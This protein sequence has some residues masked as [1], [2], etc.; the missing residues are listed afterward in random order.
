M[1]STWIRDP[2][3]RSKIN[4]RFT[5]PRVGFGAGNCAEKTLLAIHRDV[6]A[7][8]PCVLQN[9]KAWIRDPTAQSKINI[10]FTEPHVGLAA[11][12]CDEKTLLIVFKEVNTTKPCFLQY[13]KAEDKWQKYEDL[14]VDYVNPSTILKDDNLVTHHPKDFLAGI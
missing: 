5:E 11:N 4:I 12:N 14:D 2:T 9:D 7:K 3:A 8:N 1:A 6:H 13:K 10:R